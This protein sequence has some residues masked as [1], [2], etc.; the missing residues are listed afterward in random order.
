MSYFTTRKVFLAPSFDLDV[1][2]QHK[3]DLFLLLLENSGVGVVI[4]KYVK[5]TT[6]LGGRPNSN[7]IMTN[8]EAYRNIVFR[9]IDMIMNVCLVILQVE[10]D[11]EENYNNS[12]KVNRAREVIK[13][14]SR[15]GNVML[16]D[17]L[18]KEEIYD[19]LLGKILKRVDVEAVSND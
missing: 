8:S 5:N 18:S 9:N 16:I 6:S 13:D 12:I 7:Y 11:S 10:K 4:S 15:I 19:I 2:E 14:A 1:E 17:T 3:I